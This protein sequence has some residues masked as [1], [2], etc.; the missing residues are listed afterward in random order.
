MAARRWS[1]S[2]YGATIT[3]FTFDDFLGLVYVTTLISRDEVGHSD[4]LLVVFVA[5]E[6]QRWSV[7][8]ERR[9]RNGEAY[10]LVS[11]ESKGLIVLSIS[12]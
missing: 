11:F 9:G 7:L 4:D 2:A 6:T 5:V 1:A 8:Q 12:M 10:G 3:Q